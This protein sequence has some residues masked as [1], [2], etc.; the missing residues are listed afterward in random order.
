MS[1]ATST[2]T[3]MSRGIP[4]LRQLCTDLA[5]ATSRE[6]AVAR[7]L[8]DAQQHL[9]TVSG[10]DALNLSV[11]PLAKQPTATP[12][13]LAYDAASHDEDAALDAIGNAFE[14]IAID[15]GLGGNHPCQSVTT[16]TA[17]SVAGPE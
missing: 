6:D 4:T 5:V 9:I 10:P 12:G 16:P 13:L 1:V 15:Y 2:T 14:A 3:T 7:R 17:G 11:L 8:G